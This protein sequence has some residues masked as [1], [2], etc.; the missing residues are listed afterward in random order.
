MRK[1]VFIFSTLIILYA[2]TPSTKSTPNPNNTSTELSE[3]TTGTTSLVAPTDAFIKKYKGHLGKSPIELVLYHWGNGVLSG[4]YHHQK[5]SP[6]PR[7]MELSGELN[8]NET[9]NIDEYADDI[10]TGRLEGSFT[11][12]TTISGKWTATDNSTSLELSLSEISIKDPTGWS[13]AWYRNSTHSPGVLIVGNVTEKTMDFGLEVTSSGHYGLIEGTANLNGSIATFEQPVFD[14]KELCY[15]V[16]QKNK[17]L[18][19]V[20]QRSENWVCG[21]GMRANAEGK[22]DNQLKPEALEF[23]Y[24]KKDDI[25]ATEEQH[26][27]FKQLVGAYYKTFVFNMQFI[28][29]IEKNPKDQFDAEVFIGNVAGLATL[30]EAIIMINEKNEVWAAVIDLDQL[31]D[32]YKIKYFTNSNKMK[33]KLPQ[34]IEEW[35]EGFTE[36]EVVM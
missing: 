6:S 19:R 34:T 22:Y 11:E 24:G 31:N 7:K 36:Y 2:C 30:N 21:F 29:K 20:N 33:N 3:P 32:E 18:I 25:F 12:L 13:G 8:L 5:A 1:Y 17:T 16:F 15:L 14:E 10:L 28:S 9:F 35:R 23:S 4:Y 27:S 26:N